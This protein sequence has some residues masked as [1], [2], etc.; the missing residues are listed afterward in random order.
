MNKPNKRT[1]FTLIELLVVIAII[2]LLATISV[3]ALQ[4]ARAK[5][6][7]AKRVADMKQ[8][9]TALEMFFNDNNRYPT[10]EEWNAGRL[11]STT[12]GVTSTYI[13][14]IPNAPTP[15]DGSCTGNQ[16][17][18]EYIPGS[19]NSSYSI[20]FCLGGVIGS[21]ASGPKCLDPGGIMDRPCFLC[22]TDQMVIASVGNRACD[23]AAPY[24]DKCVYDTV[25]I[26]DQ[27]WM[28]QNMNIGNMTN[29]VN[30]QGD[31]SSGVEKYCFENNQINPNP[32]DYVSSGG[33]DTDG[34]LYQWHTV[35]GLP[36][37]CD[38]HDGTAPCVV[39]I[40]HQGICPSGWHIPTDEEWAALKTYLGGSG[41]AA[42][43]EAQA[44]V[45]NGTN[46]SGFNALRT[47][48]RGT[49]GIFG[50]HYAVT[51]FRSTHMDS[52]NYGWNHWLYNGDPDINRGNYSRY[53]GYSLRCLKN[54]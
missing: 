50:S 23:T 51:F 24:Y 46:S 22:G 2:G 33:C 12:T 26:G 48:V 41:V 10:A 14:I 34:G 35:M 37:I 13:Q 18:F 28:N 7:D 30:N 52:L 36:Q 4:N 6:R 8:V 44:P 20:S 38:N 45:W 53:S 11:Y 47:G 43:I 49:D 29:G 21:L 16:N 9:Q 15:A 5:S 32:T 19:D 39:N 1:A 54:N 40:N 31:Y 42:K 27:C 3:L 25:Q 17:S